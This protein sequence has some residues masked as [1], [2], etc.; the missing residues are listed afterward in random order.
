MTTEP[1]GTLSPGE[2]ADDLIEEL[3]ALLAS[4][5]RHAISLSAF[6]ADVRRIDS[7]VEARLGVQ[8]EDLGEPV[9]QVPSDCESLPEEDAYDIWCSVRAAAVNRYVQWE[10]VERELEAELGSEATTEDQR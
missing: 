4:V 8:L 3:D 2:S 7:L 5:R 10:E 9:P 1:V 6:V